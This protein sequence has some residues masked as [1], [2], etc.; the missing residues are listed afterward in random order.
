MKKAVNILLLFFYAFGS[1]FLPM[2]DFSLINDMP[3]MY[4]HCKATEDKD[5]KALDFISDHILNLDGLF[6][7]HDKGDEQKPH[8][9]LPHNHNLQTTGFFLAYFPFAFTYFQ[10][11]DVNLLRPYKLFYSTDYITKIFRPPIFV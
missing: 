1:L 3:E 10:I 2:G 9:P 8:N 4:R 6:D 5:M 11:T 7:K